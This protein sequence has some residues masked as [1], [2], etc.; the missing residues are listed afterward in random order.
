MERKAYRFV[1]GWLVYSR[2]AWLRVGVVGIGGKRVRRYFCKGGMVACSTGAAHRF[3]GGC[4][5]G[6]TWLKRERIFNG[7]GLVRR[8]CR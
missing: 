4:N 3:R 5:A 1:C 6:S 8:S 7:G 2:G